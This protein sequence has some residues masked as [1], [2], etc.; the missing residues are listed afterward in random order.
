MK[1]GIAPNANKK[2]VLSDSSGILTFAALAEKCHADMLAT[3]KKKPKAESTLNRIKDHK[4]LLIAKLG[5]FDA[6]VI[7]SSNVQDVLE[8]YRALGQTHQAR[9]VRSCAEWIFQ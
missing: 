8:P 4:D 7:R 5:K 2:Q 9:R 3:T 6:T 1:K